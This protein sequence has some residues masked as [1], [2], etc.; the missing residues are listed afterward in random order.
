MY[1][2][3]DRLGEAVGFRPAASAGDAPGGLPSPSPLAHNR[4]MARSSSAAACRLLAA[5]ALACPS[6]AAAQSLADEGR[7]IAEQHCSRCHVID[8]DNPFGGIA[9]T[10]SFQLLV[11]AFPD[12]KERFETFYGRRPHP[13]VVRFEGVAPITED[14]P[15]TKTV[16]L[17][18][19]DVDAIVA[20]VVRL[21]EAAEQAD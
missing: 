15:T 8:Q 19:S 1:R 5:A 4:A 14:P 17:K 16:D 2:H 11:T 12:W 9:S 6:G 21:K 3:A 20:Y 13:S 10:P 18:L 7:K